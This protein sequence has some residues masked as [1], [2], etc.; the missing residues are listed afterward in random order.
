M[1]PSGVPLPHLTGSCSFPALST[2]LQAAI[3]QPPSSSTPSPSFRRPGGRRSRVQHLHHHP[4]ASNPPHRHNLPSA[5]SHVV[6][7]EVEALPTDGAPAEFRAAASASPPGGSPFI[8]LLPHLSYLSCDNDGAIDSS[9]RD[10][11]AEFQLLWEEQLHIGLW[12]SDRRDAMRGFLADFETVAKEM[13]E[14]FFGEAGPTTSLSR[15]AHMSPPSAT[16]LQ[17]GVRIGNLRLHVWRDAKRGQN[18]QRCLRAF[19]QCQIPHIAL[20]LVATFQYFSVVITVSAV[21]PLDLRRPALYSGNTGVDQEALHR[22][23]EELLSMAM[24][25]LNVEPITVAGEERCGETAASSLPPLRLPS[26]PVTLPASSLQYSIRDVEVHEG[27]DGRLY[28]VNAVGLVPPMWVSSGRPA[29]LRRW[30]HLIQHSPFAW[31][32]CPMELYRTEIHVAGTSYLTKVLRVPAENQNSYLIELLHGNGL[33]VCLL[34]LLLQ[35]L[36]DSS[37]EDANHDTA[38]LLRIVAIEMLARAVRRSLRECWAAEQ[39]MLSRLSINNY[40]LR[41]VGALL[42]STEESFTKGLLPQMQLIFTVSDTDGWSTAAAFLFRILKAE[43]V[44]ITKRLCELCSLQLTRGDVVSVQIRPSRHN[45]ISFYTTEQERL[46]HLLVHDSTTRYGAPFLRSFLCPLRVQ[47]YFRGGHTSLAWQFAAHL[48]ALCDEYPQEAFVN[49]AALGV[50]AVVAAYTGRA[51][52]CQQLVDRVARIV[53]CTPVYAGAPTPAPAGAVV[54]PSPLSLGSA[55]LTLSST[56]SSHS[57]FFQGQLHVMVLQSFLLWR[58]HDIAAAEAALRQAMALHQSGGVLGQC[59]SVWGSQRAALGFFTMAAQS[60]D[61]KARELDQLWAV[62]RQSMGSSLFVAY[63]NELYGSLFLDRSLFAHAAVRLWECL[64][65][66]EAILGPAALRVAEV[67]NKLAFVYYHWDIR[68]YGLYCS[69]ILHR[70]EAII[71]QGSGL[72]SPLHLVMAQNIIAVFLQRGMYVAASQ[73]LYGLRSMPLRHASRLPRDHPAV[74]RIGEMEL[75][76]HDAFLPRAVVMI[77]HCWRSYSRRS[78]LH[79]VRAA[80]VRDLQRF[81]RG[82][83]TRRLLWRLRCG[84]TTVDAVNLQAQRYFMFSCSRPLICGSAFFSK[85]Q[86]NWNGEVQH[87]RLTYIWWETA[88]GQEYQEAVHQAV[89]AFKAAAQRSVEDLCRGARSGT[90]VPG[91]STSVVLDNMVLTRVPLRHRLSLLQ[92]QLNSYLLGVAHFPLTA[93]LSTVVDAV[94]CS[95]FVQALLPLHRQPQYLLTADGHHGPSSS[96]V[97]QSAIAEL[98]HV[99]EAA[100]LTT[101]QSRCWQGIEVVRGADHVAYVSNALGFVAQLARQSASGVDAEVPLPVTTFSRLLDLCTS[102]RGKEAIDEAE[103]RLLLGR[104]QGSRMLHVALQ[105]YIGATRFTIGQDM[106]GA[107]ALLQRC[108]ANLEGSGHFFEAS[109]FQL[110]EGRELLRRDACRSAL[111]PLQRSIYLLT[112]KLRLHAYHGSMYV[113]VAARCLLAA[114]IGGRGRVDAALL[115]RVLHAVEYGEPTAYMFATCQRFISYT[116]EA[117]ETEMHQ[118]LV[119]RRD[120]RARQLVEPE[121]HRLLQ[122]LLHE[123]QL[124]CRRG[125]TDAYHDGEVVLQTAIHVAAASPLESKW[126]GV[127]LTSYGLLQTSLHRLKEARR[128]LTKAYSILVAAV[129]PASPEMLTWHK[130]DRVLRRRVA[131]DAIRVIRGAVRVWRQRRRLEEEM[132]IQRPEEY[133]AMMALRLA[134]R[135][136]SFIVREATAR[137]LIADAESDGWYVLLRRQGRMRNSAMLKQTFGTRAMVLNDK[138]DSALCDVA[139]L[140]LATKAVVMQAAVEMRWPIVAKMALAAYRLERRIVITEYHASRIALKLWHVEQADLVIRAEF[141]AASLAFLLRCLAAEE[142]VWRRVILRSQRKTKR[143]IGFTIAQT[144]RLRHRRCGTDL[145]SFI[146]KESRARQ[147]VLSGESDDYRRMMEVFIFGPEVISDAE[148][149][150]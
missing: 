126:L 103:Q 26:S 107:A 80:V 118:C 44:A 131:A 12:G 139:T 104:D 56:S 88:G 135:L 31:S 40:L 144:F 24:A 119:R 98:L 37:R 50:A 145:R 72:Y 146:L 48:A 36:L 116:E 99:F 25:A 52:T 70:A 54:S 3:P 41:A 108:A 67:L 132:R 92:E 68:R 4:S 17:D 112:E 148:E 62:E 128:S 147:Q 122:T 137:I 85:Q 64:E 33:N 5:A 109:L 9:A 121:R 76:L 115:D 15:S 49:A 124:L 19:Q 65:M 47:F 94:G 87:Q 69:C 142:A 127:L 125:G 7:E 114:T 100:G 120:A 81:G 46:L 32:R 39:F 66:V 14:S 105:W 2:P 111:V 43:A 38:L 11:N 101:A 149:S 141:Q 95:Y 10:W 42:S 93:P 84:S 1:T 89:V 140:A 136:S 133:R 82:F 18:M 20:P 123:S 143:H 83:L 91:C 16:P 130:N 74:A 60:T 22:P 78:L 57:L 113:M 77:Q 97:I 90:A 28:I 8:P 63:I 58:L 110:T 29:P 75:R 73:R 55:P 102:G 34:G 61:A 35:F 51:E 134:R 150:F 6:R 138:F 96:A 129:H 45:Y 30:L 106:D 86:R 79:G 23:L 21:L 117:G 71:I 27:L 53:S 13:V 59:R